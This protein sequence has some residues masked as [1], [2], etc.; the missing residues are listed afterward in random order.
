MGGIVAIAIAGF[1]L[2]YFV[3]TYNVLVRLRQHVRDSWS[4]ID[5]ELQRRYDL[6]PNLVETVKGYAAH[7]REVLQA[8]VDAR[9]RAAASTGSPESQARDES[10]F[11]RAL[12]RLMAVAEAYPTLMANA[13]FLQLQEQLAVT[14]DRIQASR[15]FYNANVR[16]LNTRVEVFPS[17]LIASFFQIRKVEFFEIEG[18]ERSAPSVKWGSPT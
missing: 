6:V 5:T 17:S 11:I 8:V 3:G 18:A 7:E 14:E 13:S 15:R 12:G 10:G 2:I 16:E 4:A 1:V 9:G